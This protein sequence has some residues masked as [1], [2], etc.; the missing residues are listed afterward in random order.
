M[1]EHFKKGLMQNSL[2]VAICIVLSIVVA[3]PTFQGNR[4]VAG[5]TVH[6]MA[7]SQEA[8]S[9]YEKTGEVPLWSNSMFGGMPTYTHYMGDSPNFIYKL[10]DIVSGALSTPG[11]FFFFSLICF[12]VLMCS[13]KV[14]RWIGLIAAI[15]YTFAAYNFQI[16]SA[17]HNTKMASIAYMPLALAGAHW[18]YQK[19]YIYGITAFLLGLSLMIMNGMYQIDYYLL[20]ILIGFAIGYFIQALQEKQLKSFFVASGFLAL[21]GIMSLLPNLTGL[22]LN[23]EYVKYT[24]RGGNSE[25]TL[26]KKEKKNSGGL[27]KDYAFQ[28]S[29][30]IGETFT[31]LVP[32]LYG[33]GGFVDAG[34]SSK[35]YETLMDLGA[36][37]QNAENYSQ[38]LSTYWGAQPFVAGPVYFGALVIFLMIL[39]LLVIR[40]NLKWVLVALSVLGIMMSW[41]RHFSAL[42]YFLFDH[43]PFFNNFRTPSM[44]MV[45]PGLMFCILAFWALQEFLFGKFDMNQQLDY[46]KKAFLITGG[47]CLILTFGSKMFLSF[48]GDNDDKVKARI[49]QQFGGDQQAVVKMYDALVSDRGSVAMKDGLRSFLFIVLGAGVLWFFAKRKLSINIS[50]AVIG[51]LVAGDLISIGTRYLNSDNYISEDEFDAQ[52]AARSVDLQVQKDPD[53]YYR[54]FDLT[55]D[56]YNEAMQAYHNKCV[57]G[58]HPAKLETYQDLI[59]FQLSNGKMNWEVLNM[60]NTKYVFF[61][62]SD[63]KPA[64]QPNPK[65]CGNAWFVPNIKTVPDANSEMLAMN[66]GNFGDTLLSDT[67]F[68]AK[69]TA[70]VQQKYWKQ[71]GK[72]FVVDSTSQISLAPDGYSLN[73]LNFVSNNAQDGFAVFADIYYPAGW[74]AFIDGKETDIVKTNYLLRGLFIPAGKHSIEFKFHPDTYFKWKNVSQIASSILLLLIALG[75]ALSFKESMKKST[76]DV[77]A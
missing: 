68:N 8:K 31:L 77:S 56:P 37:E 67:A 50:L 42:N 76:E 44:I 24:M 58:Y 13:W 33:G 53:P 40:N 15:A 20:I 75:I 60:L 73:H 38:H 34:S 29:Q 49:G 52:F 36:G 35:T 55:Q 70:I 47:L 71:S 10:Q 2:I 72:T 22:M 25:I 41:G 23:K 48:K 16:I 62:G 51:L 12:F 21:F 26:D 45:I 5:D 43:L 7:M 63:N 6:W 28:W 19:K 59:D 69:L 30:G 39:G 66:A 65:A 3:L 54:V 4:L 17:G 11:Y 64:V 14:N 27:D 57:G 18:A 32:N 1:N 46:V 9:F 74:K 61:N